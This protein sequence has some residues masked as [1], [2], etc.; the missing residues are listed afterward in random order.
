MFPAGMRVSSDRVIRQLLYSLIVFC[1]IEVDV[2]KTVCRPHPVVDSSDHDGYL[3]LVDIGMHPFVRC[4]WGIRHLERGN[5]LGMPDP[6]TIDVLSASI[7]FRSPFV[8]PR[9]PKI[10]GE[11]ER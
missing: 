1:I 10:I 3:G 9:P 11:V 4:R 8:A 6:G 7:Y 2:N 5:L